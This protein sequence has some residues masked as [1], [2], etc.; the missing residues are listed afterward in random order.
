[1]LKQRA[2]LT[3]AK[4]ERSH[5]AKA[6]AAYEALRIEADSSQRSLRSVLDREEVGYR[7][8][9]IANAL[10][11]ATDD[12]A[13]VEELA[14]RPDVARIVKEQQYRLD[15]V[16]A[17]S[18]GSQAAAGVDSQQRRTVV[19][20]ACLMKAVAVATAVLVNSEA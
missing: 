10:L 1:M 9:W 8:F 5:A 17:T 2:D 20:E 16:E 14:A 3:A 12:R 15:A 6:K 7:P 18:S 13:L 4:S 19:L 11:I